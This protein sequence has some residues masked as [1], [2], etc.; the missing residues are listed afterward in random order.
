MV[1]SPLA[2]VSWQPVQL[3]SLRCSFFCGRT[4]EAPL[5]SR[6]SLEKQRWKGKREGGQGGGRDP[7]RRGP[8]RSAAPK[9]A[10]SLLEAVGWGG[11]QPV[12]APPH[13]A[14]GSP[15]SPHLDQPI[16]LITNV[17][18]QAVSEHSGAYT[19][20]GSRQYG[21]LW[22]AMHCGSA[23]VITTLNSSRLNSKQRRGKKA[24]PMER[25]KEKDP[26]MM[27]N[28]KSHPQC[29]IKHLLLW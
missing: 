18:L 4:K 22:E 17:S 16:C 1:L 28:F 26:K 25:P 6:G 27:F 15:H 20:A 7:I 21:P 10:P 13:T 14:P 12:P 11:Q 2:P 3:V 5:P 9:L 19:T 23:A 8:L 29:T 24:T